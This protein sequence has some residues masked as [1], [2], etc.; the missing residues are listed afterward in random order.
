[1]DRYSLFGDS[2]HIPDVQL[3][4]SVQLKSYVKTLGRSPGKMDD[5]SLHWYLK[6][7]DFNER[8]KTCNIMFCETPLLGDRN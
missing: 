5:F 7:C 1:M 4:T 2:I 8:K 3:E 6:L